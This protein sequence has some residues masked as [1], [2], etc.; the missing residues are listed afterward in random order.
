MRAALV[1]LLAGLAY[2]GKYAG[3]ARLERIREELPAR[4]AAAR[5]RLAALLGEELPDVEVRLADA[6]RD[7]SGAWAESTGGVLVLKTEYLVIGA[8]DLDATLV[9]E[10]FHCLHRT[11]LGERRYLATPAWARE[12]AALYVAGQGAARARVLA[13][14]AG[15]DPTLDDPVGRLVDGLDGRHGFLDYYED[16]A[17]FEAVEARHGR[18]AAL[19]LVRALLGTEDVAAAVRAA[20]GED[21]ETFE[22]A[23]EERAR[24]VLQPLV[25]EGRAPLLAARRHLDA[26]EPARALET[27]QGEGVYGP[28]AAYWAARA[29]HALGRD[30]EA[31]ARLRRGLL[32]GARTETTLLDRALRLEVE[33]LRATGDPGYAEAAARARLDLTPFAKEEGAK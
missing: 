10:L 4:V 29:L 26:G 24:A 9:H 28:A 30:R 23:A 12:G 6:G 8:Y 22:R 16:V 25:A 21:M 11:R 20:C 13:A 33:L 3:D 32:D 19:A 17:A 31:L 7:P 14:H 18:E 1:L 5:E 27:L 15:A 2:E